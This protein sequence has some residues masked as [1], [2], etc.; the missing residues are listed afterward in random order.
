MTTSP[1]S[2]A[3]PRLSIAGIL[4]PRSIAVIGASESR[5]KFGGRI[6][7]HLVQHGYAGT[8][9]PIN[10]AR[11]DI[12]GRACYAS[13][14]DTP[15]PPD[16]AILAVPGDTLVEHIEAAAVAGVGC[17]VVISTGFAEAGEEGAA[18]QAEMVD[19]ARRHGMRLVGPNCMGLIVPH[20]HMA[21]C[22]SI[23]LDTD[24]P[25]PTGSIGMISQ[26]GAL[27][28]SV[29]DR[30]STDGIGFRH[31]VSL[32]N[33]ADLEI[34][35]FLEFM[36][37]DPG[38]RA[39]CMYV[40]GF[41]DGPR[42]RAAAL[43]CRAAGK[44]LLM[45]KT[46]RTDAG[47]KSARSHTA[48]LAGAFDVLE[49]VCRD[50]GVVLAG[51]PDAMVR[52][53]DMLVR[54]PQRRSAGGVGVFS[55]SGG[56][57]GIAS[58]RVTEA[59]LHMAELADATRAGLGELL[60]PPQADNP[61]DLGGR[62]LPESVDITVPAA[63]LLLADPAVD[64]GVFVL[65]SM[66]FMVEQTQRMAAAARESGK[67]CFFALTP[68]RAIDDVRAALR[69]ID[70]PYF[71]GFEDALRALALVAQHDRLR[72]T[73]PA[74]RIPRPDDVPGPAACAG[75]PAGALTES[76]VKAALRAYGVAATREAAAAPTAAAAAEAAAG[77]GFPVALKI[78]SRDIAH[79]SDVGG[80]ALGLA[81]AAAVRA[82]AGLMLE[83]V[84]HLAPQA[85]IEGFSIQEMARGEAEIIVGARRDPSFGP[86]LL[87]GFGGVFVEVLEDVAIAPA[88]VT[89]DTARRML[90]GL[91]LAPL[92][93]GARG[94]PALDVDAVCD[95]MVRIGWLAHDLG[96][97]LV[98][99]EVNPF[100]VGPAGA[101]AT[102][103]DGRAT[104]GDGQ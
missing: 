26:S 5:A 11:A 59:G 54:H 96:E 10:R 67:P 2:P 21:L 102:A 35:D 77:L 74:G 42:F 16:V 63:Q 75:L 76:E 47:M 87:A 101:G 78:V 98:E 18:R 17:C 12:L 13:I 34:C 29:F 41:K 69:A 60:L 72:M 91:R 53:A 93:H 55:G 86:V 22:S 94:R 19:I 7:H 20:H 73:P 81:D 1:Q 65:T 43:A 85:R 38:T 3:A 57:A 51:D 99:L 8:L 89:A 32:G 70:Q 52:A 15:Q 24:A 61:I 45:V 39:I 66:P 28:V 40:E 83:R 23:V 104:L 68:G 95:A 36:V 37:E 44:P 14:G 88:P 97:R 82:A 62:K 84:A 30:A 58:D 56:G 100:I 80:V 71:D 33:Q 90:A 49:A 50:A 4:E 46:G 79:K 25:L 92:L 48:S 103:A 9:V 31:C 27:M 64:Y 6:M